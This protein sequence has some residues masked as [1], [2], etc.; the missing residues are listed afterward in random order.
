MD[1]AAQITDIGLAAARD[2][3]R[4]GVTELEVYGEMI[5]AMA[6]AGGE[7]PAITLPVVSGKKSAS[8]HALSSRKKIMPG[9]IVNV[10]VCGVF[11]RYHSDVCRTISMGE[12]SAEVRSYIE[13]VTGAL[14]VA[15]NVIKPGL[16]ISA[17]MDEMKRYYAQRDM[18]EENWWV[19]GYELGI[20]FPPD[21]V[22]A[23]YFDIHKDLGDDLFE[24]GFVSNYEANFYLPDDAGMSALIDTMVFSDTR[25]EFIHAIPARLFVVD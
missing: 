9:D 5:C 25:A 18:L 17:F 22:G 12:P 14:E 11:K 19:G 7:N 13:K 4:P 10:D 15:R 8:F 16:A 20:S 1:R 3:I 21:W 2:T 24:A 6:K 23:Y